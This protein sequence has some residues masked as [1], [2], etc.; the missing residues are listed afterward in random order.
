MEL[1]KMESGYF[2]IFCRFA[3]CL[4]GENSRTAEEK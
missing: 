3:T 2:N 4:L 1:G